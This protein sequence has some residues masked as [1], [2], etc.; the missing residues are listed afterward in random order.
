MLSLIMNHTPNLQAEPSFFTTHKKKIIC[1]TGLAGV[2]IT[3]YIIKAQYSK[4]FSDDKQNKF[5]FTSKTIS[6]MTSNPT[7]TST[8]SPQQ[9]IQQA[10]P[11]NN[12]LNNSVTTGNSN[13]FRLK[14]RNFL[15]F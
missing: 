9:S 12:S 1:F 11:D 6:P 2:V 15:G 4:K 13:S 14:K 5:F 7:N 10:E 8:Q 3:Y